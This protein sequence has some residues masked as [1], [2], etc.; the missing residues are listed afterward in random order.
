MD[1]DCWN[2]EK[3]KDERNYSFWFSIDPGRPCLQKK[4]KT[5]KLQQRTAK[6]YYLCV[7]DQMILNLI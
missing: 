6:V 5:K 1:F 4:K 2:D 3:K 7:H